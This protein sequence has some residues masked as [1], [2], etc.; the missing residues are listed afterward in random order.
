MNKRLLTVFTILFIPLFL[1]SGCFF[2]KSEAQSH[3]LDNTGIDISQ[4]NVIVYL[5]PQSEDSEIEITF[6]TIHFPDDSQLME[7]FNSDSH[8][9]PLPLSDEI[10]EILNSVEGLTDE[11]GE[12]L[13]PLAENGYYCVTHNFQGETVTEDTDLT[14][15]TFNVTLYDADAN[16]F[17]YFNFEA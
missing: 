5:T 14:G 8:F 1:F 16:L 17:Y 9:I 6:A 2:A 4:G 12:L 13:I 10:I 11:N 15:V 7:Q 3:I